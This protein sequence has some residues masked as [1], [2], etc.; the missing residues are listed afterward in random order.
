MG[1]GDP[2]SQYQGGVTRGTSID[3]HDTLLHRPVFFCDPRLE[4]VDAVEKVFLTGGPNY[5]APPVR[6]TRP[7]MREHIE[8]QESG[9]GA[10]YT[11]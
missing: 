1:Q 6:S 9:H 8:L 5:S 3:P 11:F 10:S 7:D 4:W 2:C